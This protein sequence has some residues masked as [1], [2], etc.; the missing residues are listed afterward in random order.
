MSSN[1]YYVLDFVEKSNKLIPSNKYAAL[2]FDFSTKLNKLIPSNKY[3]AY[4]FI[5]NSNKLHL[6]VSKKNYKILLFQ[7]FYIDKNIERYNEIKYS[8]HKNVENNYIDTIY[9]LNE[10]IYTNKE[11]GLTSTNEKI[12]QINIGNRLQYKDIF[13]HVKKMKLTG[14]IVFSNSDIYFDNSLELLNKS[15]LDKEKGIISSMRHDVQKNNEVNLKILIDT[16]D[17]WILHSNFNIINE[18]NLFEFKFGQ[19]G[20][21][22][23]ILYLFKILGFKLYNIPHV[24]KNYH[25]HM[26][27]IRN[28]DIKNKIPGPY[29][30]MVPLDKN[31][32]PYET[33]FPCNSDNDN[34][35]L[36]NYIKKCVNNNHNFIIP[37]IAGV[38]NSFAVYIS[39]NSNSL[40]IIN[41]IINYYRN[42]MKNNAGIKINNYNDAINYSKIYFESFKNSGLYSIWLPHCNCF[43]KTQANITKLFKK[44]TFSAQVF[45]I[46]HYIKG[47]NTIW[48]HALKGKRLLIISAF[49][50]EMKNQERNLQKIYGIDLFPNCKFVYLKPPQTNGDEPSQSFFIELKKFVIHIQN[51]KN[52]FDIALVSCG[53]Y[54][55]LVCNYIYKMGKSAIYV[56]GVL[57]MYFGIYGERWLLERRD[58]MKLYKNNY[59]IRPKKGPKNYKK[60]E[61][62]CYW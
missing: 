58:I 34:S 57:Q 49:I 52:S 2:D 24:I 19:L 27:N 40:K 15:F 18:L 25:V 13:I 6:Q 8:L 60:I 43:T 46:F 59:W 51:I 35:I 54:G 5:E 62:G 36:H 21:D 32:I 11:L 48:T 17:S 50:D 31:N 10:R 30:L 3:S 20:C 55:N 22:N 44:T 14:Y 56:G 39:L 38:E 9:L 1:N 28:Y 7:Q 26:S 42:T 61:N 29:L 12:K 33:Q 4:D 37:R 41:S 16:Q 47:M 53:G 23:K 45:D